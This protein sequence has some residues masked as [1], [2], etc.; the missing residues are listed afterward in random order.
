MSN[1][2]V[3][4]K[5]KRKRT[6]DTIFEDNGYST[7]VRRTERQTS[8]KK[9]IVVAPLS[10]DQRIK[11]LCT[12]NQLCLDYIS[13]TERLLN[14]IRS[15]Q[16]RI[17]EELEFI[18]TKPPTAKVSLTAS[19]DSLCSE[20]SDSGDSTSSDEYDGL[21]DFSSKCEN[22]EDLVFPGRKEKS[23]LLA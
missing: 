20:S 11:E 22:N 18:D 7:K 3:E 13:R 9:P 6:A 8:P 19:T 16:G 17:Q 23:N 15:E 14:L 2:S 12:K 21:L 1:K 5:N 4:K 10:K